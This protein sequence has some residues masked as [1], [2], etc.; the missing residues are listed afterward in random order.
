MNFIDRIK[1]LTSIST[2]ARLAFKKHMSPPDY[3]ALLNLIGEPRR[4]RDAAESLNVYACIFKDD[5]PRRLDDFAVLSGMDLAYSI[6][7]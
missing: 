2:D 5:V 3:A 4:R 6:W 7:T 1:H